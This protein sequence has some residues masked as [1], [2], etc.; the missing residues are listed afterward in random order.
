MSCHKTLLDFWQ[1]IVKF[2]LSKNGQGDLPNHPPLPMPPNK[3]ERIEK[4]K[5]NK[6]WLVLT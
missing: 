5:K 2:I 6:E 1:S 3:R 4:K